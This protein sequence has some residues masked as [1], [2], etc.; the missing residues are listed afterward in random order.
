MASLVASVA[1]AM[2]DVTVVIPAFDA[3]ATLGQAVA[4]VLDQAAVIVVLDGP[5]AEAEAVL[6]AFEGVEVIRL[7]VCGGAPPARNQGLAR[8][9]TDYV[10]FLDADDYVEG[11]LLTSAVA[12]GRADSADL[13]F[14]RFVFELDGGERIPINHPYLDQTMGWKGI[15]K[16]WLGGQYTPPCAVV[17]RTPFVREI[18]GWDE[19]LLKNQDGDLI[20]RALFEN[21]RIG[22]ASEG[23]G[24]YVQSHD[25]RRI[26]MQTGRARFESALRVLGDVRARSD[27]QVA[28]WITELAGAYT[29]LAEAAGAAGHGEI[30]ET[31]QAL[32]DDLKSH[33]QPPSPAEPPDQPVRGF[34]IVR[35]GRPGHRPR[36]EDQLGK[37][38]PNP[39][40]AFPAA[41]ARALPPRGDVQ[42]RDEL[43]RYH[44]HLAILRANSGYGGWLH[45]LEDDALV[46]RF[47]AE[48][49]G[50]ITGGVDFQRYDLLF[51]NV[52]LMARD[53]QFA[54]LRAMFDRGVALSPSGDVAAVRTVQTIALGGVDFG[55][56]TSYLVNPRATGRLADLLAQRLERD[57]FAPIDVAL[58]ALARERKLSM[59]CAVP[60]LTTP[61]LDLERAGE[62]ASGRRDLAADVA[63]AAFYAD[64]DMAQLRAILE[65]LQAAA[66][67]SATGDLLAE[68]YRQMIN[69]A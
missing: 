13:V 29:L 46:S 65:R 23:A 57:L 8:V 66:A 24:V 39:Y 44:A 62:G 35:D 17:W 40:E 67:P 34:Y 53:A 45:L 15:V 42:D 30:A 51:T 50:L 25:P 61:R 28:P 9:E 38:G 59:A 54:E 22:V 36:F 14:G 32:S 3:A 49:I 27:P 12:A 10:M 11:P 41:D 4:S 6:S 52:R 31:A 26:S 37:L 33:G 21:P 47:A 68:A 20:Y 18:G 63:Q 56:T 19:T 43:V 5:D 16:A 1:I 7:P 2:K 69:T 48:A 64:R 55:L 60:F 58:C